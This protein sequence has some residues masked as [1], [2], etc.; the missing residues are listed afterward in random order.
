MLLQDT[1]NAKEIQC[2]LLPLTERRHPTEVEGPPHLLLLFPPKT[3]LTAQNSCHSERSERGPRPVC[4]LGQEE[5]PHWPG[6]PF[7]AAL[8]RWVGSKPPARQALA[9]ALAVAPC[10]CPLPLPLPLP[11]AVTLASEIGLGFSPGTSAPFRTG[12]FNPRDTSSFAAPRN[13]CQ[14]LPLPN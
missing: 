7:I 6:A 10:G 11:F 1:P 2:F 14:P 12:G 9:V 3:P 13:S 8:S 5:P 4:W